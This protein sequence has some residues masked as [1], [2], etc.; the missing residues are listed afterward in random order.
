MTQEITTSPDTS[1][2]TGLCVEKVLS[3]S[4][5]ESTPDGL[6]PPTPA[7]E[8]EAENG[9]ARVQSEAPYS[10]FSATT[11]IFIIFM[12]SISALISPLAATCYYPALNPLAAQLHVSNSAITLSITTYMVRA[13]PYGPRSYHANIEH[14]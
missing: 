1:R 14:N 7:D 11:K 9:L 8:N 12:V 13:S 6:T 2:G 3:R 5:E 4:A 10:I